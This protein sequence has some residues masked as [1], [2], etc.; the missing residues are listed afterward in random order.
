M[1]RFAARRRSSKKTGHPHIAHPRGAPRCFQDGRD[2]VYLPVINV[3]DAGDLQRP[4]DSNRRRRQAR[5]AGSLQRRISD[6]SR[7]FPRTRR[8]RARMF[9]RRIPRRGQAPSANRVSGSE[10][11]CSRTPSCKTG[12]TK[13]II[14]ITNGHRHEEDHDRAVP[15]RRSGRKCSGG[16]YPLRRPPAASAPAVPR[17]MRGVGENRAAA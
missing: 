9:V 2:E 14:P 8:P 5:I 12:T 6:P 16:K 1:R 11:P 15:P 17:I 13:F 3:A 10:T 4:G 7:A